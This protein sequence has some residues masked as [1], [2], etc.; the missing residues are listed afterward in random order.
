MLNASSDKVDADNPDSNTPAAVVLRAEFERVA[1]QMYTQNLA[2]AQTNK[3]LSI[4]RA[5]DLLIIEASRDLP[6]LSTEISQAIIDASSYAVVT[7]FSLKQH[8]EKFLQFQG[9]ADN[10]SKEQQNHQISTLELLGNLHIPIEG[11]WVTSRKRNLIIDLHDTEQIANTTLFSSKTKEVLETLGTQ[12]NLRSLYFTKLKARDSLTGVMMVAL[13]EP[14]L[15]IDDIELIER[16]SEPTGIALDNRLLYEEN[17]RVVKQLQQTNDRLKEMD[18]SK[19]EFISMASHQLRTPLTSMKGYVSM[20]LDGDVG[21]ISDQQKMMLQQAFDSSQRMVYLIADLLNVSRLRTGK[22]I[23]MN[24]VTDLVQV[25]EDELS[26][27][28]TTANARKVRFNFTRPESFPKVMLDETKVRQVV[29]NFLDNALYY[30]PSGGHVDVALTAD[31]T[32][33]RY[34]VTDTGLGVP[35]EEQQ[36]LFS[37][38]YRA[39]NARKVRPDGTGLGLYM[40]RKVIV[41]Q[42]G[43]ILFHSVEG[44]GSTFGFSFPIAKVMAQAMFKESENT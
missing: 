42:G 37:K 4:L 44:E 43:A 13:E 39:Q 3:T 25:V 30:T 18:A 6:Q 10:L 19:D 23:I 36:Y 5:I 33:I 14:A 40:A 41:A 32:S 38:F 21:P 34:T 24:K 26:Q 1:Q 2:L 20:V 8:S 31:D 9:L 35:K 15:M 17:V 16:V 22:F 27:L 7:I 29:M 28:S 12:F 11:E